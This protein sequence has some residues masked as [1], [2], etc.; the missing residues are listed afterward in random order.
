MTWK[1]GAVVVL[2]WVGTA[3]VTGLAGAITDTVK[4]R[5][6]KKIEDTIGRPKDEPPVTTEGES[7]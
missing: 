3:V 5:T 2:T 1:R 7:E 4:E 6:K